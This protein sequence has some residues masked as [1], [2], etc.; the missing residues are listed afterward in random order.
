MK[1]P[2]VGQDVIA[3]GVGLYQ[4]KAGKSTSFVIETLGHAS[5]DF[6]VLITGPNSSAVP[7]RCYQ[8][9]DGNLLAEF[10]AQH[11]G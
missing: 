11:A 6:D 4:A 1:N 7:V 8:Q 10:T 3:T 5:K 2:A 9:K